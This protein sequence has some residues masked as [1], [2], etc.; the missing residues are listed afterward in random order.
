MTD[1]PCGLAGKLTAGQLFHLGVLCQEHDEVMRCP[2]PVTDANV[3]EVGRRHLAV[4]APIVRLLHA[5]GVT[6]KDFGKEGYDK[7]HAAFMLAAIAACPDDFTA[8]SG[9]HEILLAAGVRS[10]DPATWPVDGGGP[11]A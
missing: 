5:A 9:G 7:W 4:Q 8:G 6:C 11:S 1:R 2:E 10:A 3:A